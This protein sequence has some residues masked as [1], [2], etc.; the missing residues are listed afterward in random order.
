MGSDTEYPTL[1]KVYGECPKQVN[2][3]WVKNSL[4][5]ILQTKNSN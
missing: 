5:Y 4:K 3:Y 2:A 1:V